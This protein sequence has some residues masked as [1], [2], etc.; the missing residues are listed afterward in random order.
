MRLTKLYKGAGTT[1][2]RRRLQNQLVAEVLARVKGPT[3][4]RMCSFVEWTEDRVIV[5]KRFASL[6]FAFIQDRGDNELLTLQLI[7]MYVEVL[8]KYFGNVCE[9]DLVYNLSRAYFLLDELLLGGN[10]VETNKRLVASIVSKQ[11]E[12][13]E[14]YEADPEAAVNAMST[15]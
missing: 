6:Y 2:E 14:L 13:V 8:D 1:K 4:H 5:Y 7:T 3:A 12:M 11:D 10:M 15:S 9:L